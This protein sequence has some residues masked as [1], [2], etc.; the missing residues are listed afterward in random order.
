M[1]KIIVVPDSFKGTMSSYENCE[2][3]RR[4]IIAL[5]PG[6]S[7]LT[8]PI[9]DG[10]EGSVDCFL[11]ALGGER[12]SAR[13]SGPYFEEI[14][15]AYGILPGGGTAVIEMAAAAGLTLAGAMADPRITTTYGVGELMLD[16][17]RRGCKRLI[18]C[19]G[20]SST[21]DAGC[22]MAAAL[23][24]IFRR[25]DG[26]EFVPLGGTLCEVASIAGEAVCMRGIEILAMCDIDNPL[27]GERGAAYVFAPQKGADSVAVAELDAGL[28]HIAAI[29]ARDMG[30][31]V[32]EMPGGGAAGG[33][34]AGMAA[35]LGAD[36]RSG[37]NTMLEAADFD[38]A[39]DGA[40]LVISGEGRLDAQ[41]LGG[42]AVI[43]I[44]RRAKAAGVPVVAVVGGYDD[45]LDEYYA[46]GV[47]AVFS[48]NRLPEPLSVSGGHTSEN[49]AMTVRNILR[50]AKL[51]KS[52]PG[53]I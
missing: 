35:F 51:L 34:G 18:V 22:G 7:V 53:S 41:S 5:W 38:S 14:E 44:A 29:M 2:I 45:C 43:G 15:A 12:V 13:V 37:I 16:A 31:G 3:T 39:L 48:I 30:V 46:A 32:A 19:L 28:E 1:K 25:S 42:K 11:A 27:Y 23:G 52:G 8:I 10:G 50:L 20:G 49:Y 21:N 26:S 36:L 4:E 24:Y 6:C 9:A 47:S 17:V 33:M 40:D